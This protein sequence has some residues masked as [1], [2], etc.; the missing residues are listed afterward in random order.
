M[1]SKRRR[2]MF[3]AGVFVVVTTVYYYHYAL[4][5]VLDPISTVNVASQSNSKQAAASLPSSSSTIATDSDALYPFFSSSTDGAISKVPFPTIPSL[6]NCTVSFQPPPVRKDESQWRKPFW[7]PSFSSSGASNP[8]NKGDLAKDL[9]GKLTGLGDNKAVKNYH[10][11]MKKRLKRC[12]GVSETVGCT[13]GHPIVPIQPETQTQNFQPKAIVFV[14]NFVTAFPASLTD[15][16]I[17]YHKAQSQNAISDFKKLRDEWYQSTFESWKGLLEWWSITSDTNKNPYQVAMYV[18]FEDLMTTDRS[19]GRQMLQ[20]L[21]QVLR[22]GGFEA[23]SSVDDL[24]CIWYGTV[25]EE[26]QRQQSIMEYIPMYTASQKDW[27]VE[28]L[29]QYVQQV[30][31]RAAKDNSG[32]SEGALATILKRYAEQVQDFANVEG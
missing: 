27:I 31:G 19:T 5:G 32:G 14:R 4:G 20:K 24:D 30:N 2:R 6:E 22:D 25:K 18:P 15:K 29:Q 28:H 17:A 16:N 8:T 26:W 21:S 3:I 9:I 1:Q 23:A 7:I 13:Q 11:S 12:H 10:M